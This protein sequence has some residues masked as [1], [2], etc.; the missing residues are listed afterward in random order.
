MLRSCCALFSEFSSIAVLAALFL[1]LAPSAAR[2]QATFA[3]ITGVVTDS[4]SARIAGVEV[5]AR[6][7]E[8]NYRSTATSNE[9]GAYNLPQLREGNYVLTARGQG[10]KEYTASDITLGMKCSK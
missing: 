3:T 10:F 7:V 1:L 6:Q 4:T 8:T 9:T 2:A 5:V